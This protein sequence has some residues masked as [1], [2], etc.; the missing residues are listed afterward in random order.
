VSDCLGAV[1]GYCGP[2]IWAGFF[3]PVG[4]RRLVDVFSRLVLGIVKRVE[5]FLVMGS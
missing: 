2:V 4:L 1:L 3:H 5:S